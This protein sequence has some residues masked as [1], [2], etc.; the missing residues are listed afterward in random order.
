[1]YPSHQSQANTCR[2]KA[3]AFARLAGFAGSSTDRQRL[4]RMHDACVNMAANEDW[5]AGTPPPPPP[6]NS[7]ALQIPRHAYA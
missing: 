5:L 1:M 3:K 4:L 2:A 6:A 7:N